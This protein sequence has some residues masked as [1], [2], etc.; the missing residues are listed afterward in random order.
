MYILIIYECCFVFRIDFYYGNEEGEFIW[1]VIINY[2][3][4]NVNLRFFV[5]DRNLEKFRVFFVVLYDIF[6]MVEFF[7]NY[8]DMN[9]EFYVDS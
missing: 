7:W 5:V 2:F 9:W 4:Y 1:G 8:N 6:E 3:F